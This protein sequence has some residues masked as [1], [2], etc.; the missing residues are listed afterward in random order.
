MGVTMR[1]ALRH[2]AKISGPILHSHTAYMN[3]THKSSTLAHVQIWRSLNKSPSSNVSKAGGNGKS[4]SS[5]PFGSVGSLYGEIFSGHAKPLK[6]PQ[7]LSTSRDAVIMAVQEEK[8]TI[9]QL[10]DLTKSR[11]MVK[12]TVK[13]FKDKQRE[14]HFENARR[15]KL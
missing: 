4:I 13:E 3:R 11:Q 10:D 14:I 2:H 8:L 9:D 15:K 12:V 6:E 1:K 5:V 7:P